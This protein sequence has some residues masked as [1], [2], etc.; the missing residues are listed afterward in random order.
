[1]LYGIDPIIGPDLLYVLRAMGH[2]DELV[3]VD[4]NY[5]A[6]SNRNRVVR[7]DGVDAV[8]AAEAILSLMPLDTFVEAAAHRMQVVDDP[9]AVPEV[10]RAFQE[11]VARRSPGQ[12]VGSIERFAFYE[13]CKGTFA[14]VVTGE[15]RLYG[16]LILKKGIIRP[17]ER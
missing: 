16:N 9:D 11:L 15:E 6:E 3:I 17:E 1:M 14:T 7:L 5:P 2:G 13:R 12:T 4:A 10:C 8:R